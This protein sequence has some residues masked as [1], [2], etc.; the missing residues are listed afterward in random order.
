MYTLGQ[1]PELWTFEGDSDED[2]AISVLS[3]MSP[4]EREAVL[5]GEVEL[6]GVNWK[7]FWKGVGKVASGGISNIAKR[8]RNKRKSKKKT[9][10]STP[11]IK[12][13]SSGSRS[14]SRR[15]RGWSRGRSRSKKD[16]NMNTLLIVGG[17]GL[18]AFLAMSKRSKQ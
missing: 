13:R 8:I 7:K 15:G 17:V 14:R 18:V 2:Y 5:S 11:P 9:G 6:L 16:M 12:T 3:D 1:Q 10:G 4:Q